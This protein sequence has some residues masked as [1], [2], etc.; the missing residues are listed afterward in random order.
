MGDLRLSP[1]PDAT[2]EERRLPP[3]TES[4]MEAG[5]FYGRRGTKSFL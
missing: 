1:P 2:V 5:E 4:I 3:A